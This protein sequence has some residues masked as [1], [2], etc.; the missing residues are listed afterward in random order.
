MTNSTLT[1]VELYGYVPSK[2]L[3]MVAVVCFAV[4]ALP[5][6]FFYLKYRLRM[7][8]LFFLAGIGRKLEIFFFF[9]FFFSAPS[10]FHSFR[11]SIA[12]LKIT[13]QIGGYVCRYLSAQDPSNISNFQTEF[14]L[15]TT[16]PTYMM[17]ANYYVLPILGAL[18]GR[19]VL[20]MRP[21]VYL[22]WFVF[23]SLVSVVLQS[24]GA[25]YVKG[26]VT[27]GYTKSEVGTKLVIAGLAVQL[28]FMLFYALIALDM[29][30]RVKRSMSRDGESSFDP[31]YTEIRRSP[32]L[33]FLILAMVVCFFCI[34]IRTLVRLIGM[35]QGVAG[36][37]MTH[38]GYQIGLEALPVFIGAIALTV[39]HPGVVMG[40]IKVRLS[41]GHKDILHEETYPLSSNNSV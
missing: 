18:Y 22:I 31:E 9:F 40:G 20:P 29:Y 28:A 10:F 39:F 27:Y 4:V 23:C 41:K 25:S 19:H 13:V 24:I 38:E 8:S 33:K 26:Y 12:N 3:N 14:V 30:R 6:L 35:I 1:A 7:F 11:R 15:L 32:K 5:Q 21:V 17:S 34:L 16:G 2:A 36:H 37:I